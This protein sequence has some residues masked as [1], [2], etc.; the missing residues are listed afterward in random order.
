MLCFFQ[1]RSVIH[2]VDAAGE[3]ALT[4]TARHAAVREITLTFSVTDVT[5]SVFLFAISNHT[6]AFSFL[7]HFKN[8]F[9]QFH[10]TAVYGCLQLIT[11]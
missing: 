5:E 4:E 3:A 11:D 1:K 9:L 7:R 8:V 2:S 6:G 10:Q